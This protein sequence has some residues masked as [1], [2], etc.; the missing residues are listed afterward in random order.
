MLHWLPSVNS[1]IPM[2]P[3]NPILLTLATV[4]VV[5][6]GCETATFH[7]TH[8][9]ADA[10]ASQ[11]TGIAYF[12]PHGYV[13]LV[14]ELQDGSNSNKTSQPVPAPKSPA[15]TN[16]PAADANGP[17]VPG[18][19]V[20]A[21]LPAS[22][23]GQATPPAAPPA[24]KDQPAA[25][26][27]PTP[28]YKITVDVVLAPDGSNLFLLDP[29][30]SAWAHDTF[31]V[32][33]K[34]GLLASIGST[35]A[36]QTGQV[37]VKLAGLAGLIANPLKVNFI[38]TQTP[39][40][41][42]LP[43]RMEVLLAPEDSTDDANTILQPAHLSIKVKPLFPK[44]ADNT[45]PAN[46]ETL[47]GSRFSA[48]ANN[49]G[50]FYRP[51]QP[52]LVTVTDGNNQD[53]SQAVVMLPN[54]APILSL[55]PRRTTFVTAKTGITFDKGSPV[56]FSYDRESVAL[57]SLPLDMA[58]AFLSVPTEMLQLKLNLANTNAQVI[59]AQTTELQN[60]L[61]LMRQQL[62]LQDFIRTNVPAG[63]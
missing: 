30:T 63:H 19:P 29:Q 7:S 58:K 21:Q 17:E 27:P 36:D 38:D 42:K 23:D 45:L 55:V 5:F 28:Y 34:D 41:K 54:E 26:P 35:N 20:L 24:Q 1:Q 47:Y 39:A 22:T 57:A 18:Q 61:T 49:V 50:L 59:N 12:L 37:L 46:P 33:I 9:A 44:A 52:Y 48:P 60:E 2:K 15:P 3:V 16:A 13:H 11:R 53:V 62:S 32:G 43:A 31:N 4:V 40:P 6:T 56:A 8:T 10:P 14:A 51:L 25:T